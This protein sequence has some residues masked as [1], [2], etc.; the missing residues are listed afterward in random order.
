[1]SAWGK[2]ALDKMIEMDREGEAEIM[3]GRALKISL[4]F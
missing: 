1:M 3:I 4:N 2:V